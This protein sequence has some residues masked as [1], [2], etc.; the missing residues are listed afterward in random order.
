MTL[1]TGYL[2]K[3]VYESFHSTWLSSTSIQE[4]S[5]TVMAF[6]RHLSGVGF[7][8]KE[9]KVLET[10]PG[11]GEP[12]IRPRASVVSALDS[13]STIIELLLEHLL[14]QTTDNFTFREAATSYIA[15]AMVWANRHVEEP[16]LK[17][18]TT[19]TLSVTSCNYRS[20]SMII[21]YSIKHLNMLVPDFIRAQQQ[22]RQ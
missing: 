3:C 2:T 5:S 22:P 13:A 12:F 9:D 15:L 16:L 11:L 20:L 4:A 6:P 1:V 7:F 10:Y 21:N 19:P 17:A 14:L 18:A 8:M